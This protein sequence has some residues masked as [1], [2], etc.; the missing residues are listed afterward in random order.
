MVQKLI[1]HTPA[2]S[3]KIIPDKKNCYSWIRDVKKTAQV[4]IQK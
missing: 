3:L 2:G 1:M 4:E